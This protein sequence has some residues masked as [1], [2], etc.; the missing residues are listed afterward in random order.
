M[1]AQHL[2][3]ARPNTTS[4]YG[5]L[6]VKAALRA[7]PPPDLD[8]PNDWASAARGL[9]ALA[10]KTTLAA[11]VG[12]D[13]DP[14]DAYP[15]TTKGRSVVRIRGKGTLQA[16]LLRDTKV[17]SID[18]SRAALTKTSTVHRAGASLNL[19]IPRKGR[20][21]IVV[22]ASQAT[23]PIGYTLRAG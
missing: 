13:N 8:E 12:G 16:Y 7:V 17:A 11:T 6:D 22:T 2:S 18:P 15:I 23:S 19:K 5:L 1:S 3:G 20:W 10:H 9:G 14:L 4:G 21:Y